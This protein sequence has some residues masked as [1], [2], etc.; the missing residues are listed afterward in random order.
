MSPDEQMMMSFDSFT[1][2]CAKFPHLIVLSTYENLLTCAQAAGDMPAPLV[3]QP[4]EYEYE[5]LTPRQAADVMHLWANAQNQEFLKLHYNDEDDRFIPANLAPEVAVKVRVPRKPLTYVEVL[6]DEQWIEMVRW[7][8]VPVELDKLF[9][10]FV[11][12]PTDAAVVLEAKRRLTERGQYSMSL[13][14]RDGRYH[15]DGPVH[16]DPAWGVK[17]DLDENS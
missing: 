17:L 5:E 1:P 13:T 15:W 11:V 12:R 8:F 14:F 9:A 6:R 3:W 10:V 4:C 7:C 16:G 2:L